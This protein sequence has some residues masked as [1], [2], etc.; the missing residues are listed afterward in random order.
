MHPGNSVNDFDPNLKARYVESWN[1]GF[2]RSLT[3][4]TVLEVRYIGN[5]SARFWGLVA[6][7]VSPFMKQRS[8]PNPPQEFPAVKI[9]NV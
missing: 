5:H 8:P 6:K 3:P 7:F 4:D 9:R 2:Q 1:L